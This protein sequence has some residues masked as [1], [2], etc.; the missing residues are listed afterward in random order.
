MTLNVRHRSVAI[1]VGIVGVWAITACFF[2]GLFVHRKID[3]DMRQAATEA[4][5]DL[6]RTWLFPGWWIKSVASSPLTLEADGEEIGFVRF[7]TIRDPFRQLIVSHAVGRRFYTVAVRKRTQEWTWVGGNDQSGDFPQ[8]LVWAKLPLRSMEDAERIRQ[9]LHRF[10]TTGGY[11]DSCI[12]RSVAPNEWHIACDPDCCKC[13]Y[14]IKTDDSG[15][16]V[17]AEYHRQ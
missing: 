14:H 8:F 9:C 5:A 1:I 17:A 2:P 13:A 12:G 7:H 4:E 15:R 3:A 11:T 16:I 6:Y 10:A